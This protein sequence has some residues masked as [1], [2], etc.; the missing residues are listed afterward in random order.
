MGS[1]HEVLRRLG[2]PRHRCVCPSC[3]HYV[4]TLWLAF[5]ID[6][7][8]EKGIREIRV[9]ESCKS[10]IEKR[11]RQASASQLQNELGLERANH[12]HQLAATR[13]SRHD[14]LIACIKMRKELRM[15]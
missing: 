9:C 10:D 13:S 14:Y 6:P 5:I 11:N 15:K 7:G 4:P 1:R 12:E 8:S 3:R 2:S